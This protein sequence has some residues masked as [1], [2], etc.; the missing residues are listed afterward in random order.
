[1]NCFTDSLLTSYTDSFL[2]FYIAFLLTIYTDKILKLDLLGMFSESLINTLMKQAL[3]KF[4]LLPWA[5]TVEMWRYNLFSGQIKE[6][7]MT[8]KWWELR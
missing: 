3:S 2:T 1:M 7:D 6:K 4:V 5:L 8:S